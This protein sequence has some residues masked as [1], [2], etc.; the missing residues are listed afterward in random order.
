[1]ELLLFLIYEGVDSM[2]SQTRPFPTCSLELLPS[3]TS[4]PGEPTAPQRLPPAF[5]S[6]VV[7]VTVAASSPASQRAK[8]LKVM[9]HLLYQLRAVI[10]TASS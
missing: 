8:Q 7:F 1:M 10:T 3:A 5:H 9:D 2:W 4:A 6:K